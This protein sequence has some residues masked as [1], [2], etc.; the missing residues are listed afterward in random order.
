MTREE[1]KQHCIEN[2]ENGYVPTNWVCQ[3]DLPDGTRKLT[4]QELQDLAEFIG[5]NDTDSGTYWD[6]V[7]AWVTEQ[8]HHD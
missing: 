7:R 6:S 3:H 4:D 1:L 5:E 8:I 2:V